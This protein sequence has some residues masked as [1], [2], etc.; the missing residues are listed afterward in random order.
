MTMSDPSALDF[1]LEKSADSI[2]F[3]PA[4]EAVLVQCYDNISNVY[5]ETA[6]VY[7]PLSAM[8]AAAERLTWEAVNRVRNKENLAPDFIADNLIDGEFQRTAHEVLGDDVPVVNHEAENLL[9]E[10]EEIDSLGKV[11]KRLAGEGKRN[12]EKVAV[13]SK[14]GTAFQDDIGEKEDRLT[15]AFMDWGKSIEQYIDTNQHIVGDETG[16][17]L[18]AAR[19]IVAFAAEQ[20]R[21]IATTKRAR[22]NLLG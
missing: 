16:A 2:R 21:N 7:A 8:H 17:L 10:L 18:Q 1:L 12:P 11:V 14:W 13:V 22:I 15:H 5:D 20:T 3:H 4:A 19:D 9:A 6:S